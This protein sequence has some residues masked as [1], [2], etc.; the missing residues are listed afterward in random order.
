MT[1]FDRRFGL[2]AFGLAM[3]MSVSAGHALDAQISA[4]AN[5]HIGPGADF[6]IVGVV[7]SEAD[8]RV[9]GCTT[10][11]GWCV[12]RHNGRHGWVNSASVAVTGISRA[13]KKFDN[14]I[15]VINVAEQP[16][17]AVFRGVGS[18]AVPVIVEEQGGFSGNERRVFRSSV[19]MAEPAPTEVPD[20]TVIKVK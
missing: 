13:R 9:N 16:G 10:G 2:V 19:G 8:V 5:M 15:I 1:K 14:P 18:A 12:V 20:F 17:G 7:P 6:P 4:D 3:A 11:D